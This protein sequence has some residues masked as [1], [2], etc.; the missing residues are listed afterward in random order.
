MSSSN[1]KLQDCLAHATMSRE[2]QL[3]RVMGNFETNGFILLKSV[4]ADHQIIDLTNSIQGL[5]GS[6]AGIRHLLR[7]CLPVRKLASAPELGEIT[8]RF[9]GPNAKPVK[10]IVFDKTPIANWYVTW[11][12][13]LTIAVEKR[14]ELAG[15]G[16]WSRKDGVDHVQPPADIL[17]NMIAIRIHLDACPED[18]G[19][20]RFFPGSHMVG[21]LDPAEISQ[22]RDKNQYV[23]C[24]A[25]RGDA[26]VMRPLVLHS[27]GKAKTPDHRRVLHIEYAAM[28]LPGGLQWSEASALDS[29]ELIMAI[30]EE[31][32]LEIPDS[33][34]ER[35]VTVGDAYEYLKGRLDS[36]PAEE[37]LCQK[38]FYKLRRAL[39][40]NFDVK[41][42][43]IEPDSKMTDILS[44]E[45][46]ESGWPYLE[47]F[48]EMRTPDFKRANEILGFKLK[49]EML[50]FRELVSALISLNTELY[51]IER[52]SD[53][54][55][56]RRLK[57][58]IIR[59]LRIDP[60]EV[61]PGASF[62]RDLGMC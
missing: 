9:L 26:I 51:V 52:D 14:M 62:A 29:I 12:Q 32:G 57:L 7:R 15:F 19:A 5:E 55:I 43:L 20:L 22:W 40:A 54:E 37:C 13:D 1:A 35:L 58:I 39:I 48:I 31:F 33:T 2:R 47:L 24:A 27:S 56:W 38:I 28:D 41:R 49:D 4:I 59:Q 30:E 6:A 61:V 17:E 46:I 16:P 23:C 53:Q 42:N 45:E 44:I 21:K 18:N 8:S 60:D 25:E 3:E 36:V 34:A 50:T 11:H 10:A